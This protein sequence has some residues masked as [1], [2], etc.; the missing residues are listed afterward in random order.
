MDKLLEKKLESYLLEEPSDALK[1]EIKTLAQSRENEFELKDRLLHNLSFGTAGIRAKMESGYNRMNLVS[2]FRF[3]HSFAFTILKQRQKPK[4]VIG[5][6]ARLNSQRFSEEI[7]QVLQALGIKTWCF[8][9]CVP[10]PLCAFAT[11]SLGADF[12]VMVTASHNPFL[13]NGIKIFGA[14]SRQLIGEMLKVI[15][16]NMAQATGRHVFWSDKK[17]KSIFKEEYV[18]QEIFEK[19]FLEIAYSKLFPN[20][21]LKRDFKFV[22]T[23]LCGVG[24]EYFFKA[25]KAEGFL[26]MEEVLEQ[27]EPNGHFPNLKFPNPEEN[28]VLDLAYK[29]AFKK[30]ISFVFANDPDADR[31]S[32][33]ALNNEQKMQQLS[34]NEMGVLLGYFAIKRALDQGHKPLVATSIVSSRM[35]KAMAQKMGAIY[36]ESL[37]GFGNIA[38]AALEKEKISSSKLVFAYE[39][40]IGFLIDKVVLDKDGINAGLRFLEIVS[41]LEQK[42]QSVWDFLDELYLEFGLFSSLQH[43]YRFS[44]PSAKDKMTQAMNNCRNIDLDKLKAS[45]KLSWQIADLNESGFSSMG[46]SNNG[47]LIIYNNE[48]GRMLV[49]PSGTE[50]KIKIYLELFGQL[51]DPSMLK[52]EKMRLNTALREIAVEM[53]K[54]IMGHY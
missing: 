25:A 42:K 8:N 17:N 20:Q 35:L 46:L 11:K 52:C 40:A 39:E 7:A 23:P 32:V 4:I 34:G 10:T 19:Y 9:K 49:R 18:P 47:N 26:G 27:S 53:G 13:D 21:P 30:R 2:V 1:S 6:D 54:I 50:A 31:L 16:Q 37:T 3:A 45:T 29:L 48:K 43:S 51:S 44:G 12:G 24:Q 5:Y 41:F 36:A 15:E 22:Y 33:S 28:G 14:D 38:Q